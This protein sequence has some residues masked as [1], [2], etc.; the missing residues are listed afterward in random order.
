[1]NAPAFIP[2]PEQPFT[3]HG[4]VHMCENEASHDEGVALQVKWRQAYR[5]PADECVGCYMGDD[6]PSLHDCSYGCEY[7]S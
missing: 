4:C 5:I 6:G 2:N 7:Y 1:M 3:E